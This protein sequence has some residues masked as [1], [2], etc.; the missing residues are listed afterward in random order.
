MNRLLQ[1]PLSAFLLLSCAYSVSAHGGEHAQ[2]VVAPDADW[3]T[4][5]MAGMLQSYTY[6]FEGADKRFR[7]TSH[8]WLRRH[9]LFQPSRL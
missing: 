3:P 2:V 5:H 7:G 8:L 9:S 1:A 6:P 4:R